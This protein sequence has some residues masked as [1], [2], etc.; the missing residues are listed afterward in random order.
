MG[1]TIGLLTALLLYKA[2]ASKEDM[3]L[4]VFLACLVIIQMIVITMLIKRPIM[5]AS[6]TEWTQRIPN[7][8]WMLWL[9][10]LLNIITFL[11]FGVDKTLAVKD[12]QRVPIV[13]LMIIS[14]LGGALGGY[15][16]MYL[17]HHKTKKPYFVYGLPMMIVMHVMLIITIT[18]YA[19]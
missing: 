1:G 18:L 12:K 4:R 17:F 11:M 5:P 10:L 9:F 8:P 15:L 14:Y 7:R 13:T 19:K 6:I 3:L 16:A 2:K